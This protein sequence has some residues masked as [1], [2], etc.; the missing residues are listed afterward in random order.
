MR[1]TVFI[2][3]AM[4]GLLLAQS[5][6]RMAVDEGMEQMVAVMPAVGAGTYA[7]P[8]RPALLPAQRGLAGVT[9][10]RY[11]FSDDGKRVAVYLAAKTRSA[12]A[13][14]RNAGR[15]DVEVYEP[16]QD[17][18][19]KVEKALEKVKKGLTLEDLKSGKKEVRP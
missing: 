7:D 11:V 8:R 2:A 18:K 1:C 5:G 17:P 3:V 14:L 6:R 15:A 13:P 4:G 12:F 16:H 10:A 19:E 9:T